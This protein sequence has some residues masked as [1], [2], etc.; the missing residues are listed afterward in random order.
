MQIS[1]R[2]CFGI[3]FCFNQNNFQREKQVKLGI[4]SYSLLRRYTVDCGHEC[5]GNG[6]GHAQP[7]DTGSCGRHGGSHGDLY[8]G[9]HT[10]Q[11]TRGV[12]GLIRCTDPPGNCRG[13]SLVSTCV[14]TSYG[15]GDCDSINIHKVMFMW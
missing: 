5:G 6:G 11:E 12:D 1:S 2:A 8:T 7:D 4:V 3:E 13:T 15:N 10:E 14:T 9:L